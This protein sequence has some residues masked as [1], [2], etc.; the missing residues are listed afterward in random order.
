MKLQ[1][2]LGK[3]I[4][5]LSIEHK[6][7][8]EISIE[9]VNSDNYKEY[10]IYMAHTLLSS[11]LFYDE[12]IIVTAVN[13]RPLFIHDNVLLVIKETVSNVNI[14]TKLTLQEQLAVG[15]LIEFIILY[16]QSLNHAPYKNN[17]QSYHLDK[18]L[19]EYFPYK[20]IKERL[21]CLNK[22]YRL[23]VV[24]NVLNNNCIMPSYMARIKKINQQHVFP[25]DSLMELFVTAAKQHRHMLDLY[26]WTPDSVKCSQ[27]YISIFEEYLSS[28]NKSNYR[29]I[30]LLEMIHN[31]H[32]IET[33]AII[34]H[35]VN[36]IVKETNETKQHDKEPIQLLSRT[37]D[38]LKNIDTLK[39]I[40]GKLDKTY[41]KK[42]H[43]CSKYLLAYKRNLITEDQPDSKMLGLELKDIRIPISD[44]MIVYAKE[45][46]DKN[47]F[48]AYSFMKIDID[49]TMKD[50]ILTKSQYPLS[51]IARNFEIDSGQGVYRTENLTDNGFIKILNQYGLE[52][53]KT[54]VQ[55]EDGYQM[56]NVFNEGF[57]QAFRETFLRKYDIT[58]SI[59][60]KVTDKKD[61]S[62]KFIEELTQ[63]FGLDLRSFKTFYTISQIL[64]QK[65]IL[66]IEEMLSRQSS[67]EKI[68]K[69]LL[70]LFREGDK[71]IRNDAFLLYF[72]LYAHDGYKLRHNVAH[73][74]IIDSA[75]HQEMILLLVSFVAMRNIIVKEKKHEQQ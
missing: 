36:L 38:L 43:E 15:F 17:K 69:Y 46:M 5:N 68:E 25:K 72:V 41:V 65:V 34:K 48:Y 59:L 19:R 22:F 33:K 3:E 57:Y 20:F 40:A 6:S 14:K 39:R 61:L 49:K 21:P 54:M 12:G 9:S 67:H 71:E 47:I 53:Q 60:L 23:I 56:P 10:A 30:K 7:L 11:Y 45:M 28:I 31:K 55:G 70:Y 16:S 52:L 37:E 50:A 8:K 62:H 35:F 18:I 64:V 51:Y 58:L 24:D 44:D 75:F 27:Q 74:N 32:K 2:L 4:E 13:S 66:M 1:K 63:M 29:D 73:G 42:L 26:N